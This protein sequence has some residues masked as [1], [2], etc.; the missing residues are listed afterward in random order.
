MYILFLIEKELIILFDIYYVLVW[1]FKWEILVN[2][3]YLI[4]QGV[5]FFFFVNFFD[6]QG[7][8][9]YEFNI[10]DYFLGVFRFVFD[11]QFF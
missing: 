6:V 5:E 11:I 2:N 10:F 7:Y 3:Q 8:I 4:D 9:D 1:N